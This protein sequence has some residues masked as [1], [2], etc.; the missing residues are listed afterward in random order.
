[1]NQSI[2]EP[3]HHMYWLLTGALFCYLAP[4]LA[5]TSMALDGLVYANIA[6]LLN[7]SQGSFWQLPFYYTDVARFTD[8]PP[9]GIYLQSMWMTLL[10]NA[11][12]VDK[13]WSIVLT[14]L[15]L[16]LTV[17]AAGQV[18]HAGHPAPRWWLILLLALMPPFTYTLKNGFL[19]GLLCIGFLAIV[20][21][22]TRPTRQTAWAVL[23]G[24]LT[25]A[26]V[27]IKGPVGLFPLAIPGVLLLAE[28][29]W[30]RQ[31]YH[32]I[33]T[34]AVMLTTAAIALAIVLLPDSA[35]SWLQAYLQFQVFDSITGVRP[36]QHGRLYLLQHLAVSLLILGLLVALVTRGRP[37]WQRTSL[38][39]LGLGFAFVLPLLLSGRHFRHYLLPA[40]PFFALAA[41]A[42]LPTIKLGPRLARCLNIVFWWPAALAGVLMLVSWGHPGDHAETQT[43]AAIVAKAAAE[44]AP[45]YCAG[46]SHLEL[47]AYLYRQHQ[48][49]STNLVDRWLICADP[50][51][52]NN[53]GAVWQVAANLSD[54]V[55]L[56]HKAARESRHPTDNN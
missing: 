6:Q 2:L 20:C 54:G 31:L 47:A 53:T 46:V 29:D 36:A 42:A 39:W 14:G 41:W 5:S 22:V 23:A 4:D 11:W 27:L 56:W 35:Q 13:L 3:H 7:D 44:Q 49:Q 45:A 1:M 15:V 32:T 33:K 51:T 21:C 43:D 34:S 50:P 12:W 16:L 30:R 17:I 18:T 40:L 25:A 9:L 55:K 10:G 19:E 24:A 8:H 37:H 52:A 38:M 26:C 28:T 48:V